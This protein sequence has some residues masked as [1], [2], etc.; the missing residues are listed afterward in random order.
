MS[1]TSINKLVCLL[2]LLYFPKLKKTYAF[3]LDCDI[4]NGRER[5][6]WASVFGD[7]RRLGISGTRIAHSIQELTLA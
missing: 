6:L 5:V 1:G 4:A 2:Q 3:F 7:N